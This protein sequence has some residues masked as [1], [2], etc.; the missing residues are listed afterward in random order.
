MSALIPYLFEGHAV[1]ILDQAGE[2]WFVARDVAALL[3]Y[4]DTDYA[5]RAHCKGAGETQVPSAGGPQRA[6]IIPERDVY[7]LIVRSKL[8]T[9]EVFE[10]WVFGE[11]LPSI[12]KTGSYSPTASVPQTFSQALRLAADQAEQIEAQR[13]QLAIA[14]P[15]AQ[16][17]DR[18]DG[19]EGS[20]CITAAAKVL[21][22]G[23]RELQAYLRQHGWTYRRPGGSAVLGYQAKIAAGMLEHKVTKLE[24]PDRPEKIVE[25]VLVTAKGLSR[26]AQ[27]L[28]APGA[29]T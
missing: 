18:L 22:V 10:D 7:R 23:P 25:Q 2:P 24:R 3:G 15:K 26:L 14:E 9:A 11:V 1:R 4:Q 17:L 28:V 21:K 8:P 19:A 6:K 5:I 20:M 27:L 16:A 29:A 12:R 13:A